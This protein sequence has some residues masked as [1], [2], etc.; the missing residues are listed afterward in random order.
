[1]LYLVLTAHHT[2]AKK[3]HILQKLNTDG[4]V[5]EEEGVEEL[6]DNTVG[7]ERRSPIRRGRNK[8]LPTKHVLISRNSCRNHS[9]EKHTKTEKTHEKYTRHA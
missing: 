2:T 6:V 4:F 3:P 1:M 5:R 9:K 8:R 7:A